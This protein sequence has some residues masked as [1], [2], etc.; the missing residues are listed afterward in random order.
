MVAPILDNETYVR[1]VY[2]P[3]VD[4]VWTRMPQGDAVQGGQWL[5]NVPVPLDEVLYFILDP[6][7]SQ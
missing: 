5:R 3:P 7:N 6:G 2:L 1:D 4:G